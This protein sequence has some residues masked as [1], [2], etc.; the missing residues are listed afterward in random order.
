MI[1]TCEKLI[2]TNENYFSK[3]NS[4]HYLGSS[5][6]KDFSGTLGKTPCEAETIAKLDGKWEQKN[7]TALLVGSYVDS[8]FEGTL[9]VFKA[10][11]PDLFMKN[12][13]L[14]ADFRQ[15]E[16]IIQRLERDALFMQ[17]MGGEKQ[18]IMTANFLGAD[19]KIKID[20]YHPNVCIVDLKVMASLTKANWVKDTGH[21]NFIDYWGYDIQAAIYQ[22]VVELNTGNKLPF[23]I[24]G[25]SKE[26]TTNL[27]VIQLPQSMMDNALN[28]IETNIP[29]ILAL[30]KK[31]V[32]P[33]RCEQ[34]DY[35]R[36]T[37]VLTAPIPPDMLLLDI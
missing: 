4:M 5:Q 32:A 20:S 3:E 27:E 22:K 35:C 19:W 17:F 28:Q 7:T 26:K 34:C 11:H 33:D 15:A 21:V 6:Y 29:R 23:Y 8:H 24:A 10:Q 18:V 14:K 36:F 30:K 31:E 25:A 13:G 16:E 1:A 2:L 12:G 37:K 9:D